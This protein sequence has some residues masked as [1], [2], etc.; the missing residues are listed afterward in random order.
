MATGLE[1]GANPQW[2]PGGLT[3][4]GVREAIMPNVKQGIGY[5]VSPLDF[6]KGKNDE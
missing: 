3:D 6:G 2:V 4:Q 1:A 5:D